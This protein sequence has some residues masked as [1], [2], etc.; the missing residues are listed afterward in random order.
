MAWRIEFSTEAEHDLELVFD[1]SVDGY[2]EFRQSATC[3][4]AGEAT[5]ALAGSG[6]QCEEA[7]GTGRILSCP[8]SGRRAAP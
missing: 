5:R 3:R 8:K 2:L 1:H 4:A 7:R 6:P